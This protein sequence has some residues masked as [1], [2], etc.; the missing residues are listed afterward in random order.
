MNFICGQLQENCPQI[1]ST[2][3]GKISGQAANTNENI[4]LIIECTG[5]RY[6]V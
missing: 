4:V 3:V 5:S 1:I 6:L 2:Y